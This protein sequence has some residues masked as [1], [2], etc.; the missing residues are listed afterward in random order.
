MVDRK[1]FRL[2]FLIIVILLFETCRKDGTTVES[3]NVTPE[4]ALKAY[5]DNGDTT[6]KWELKNQLKGI[7]VTYFQI[8]LT[9]Q[10]WQTIPWTHDLMVVVP[11][12]MLYNDALLIIN[13]GSNSNGKPNTHS[14]TES[15]IQYAGTVALVQKAV[16]VL[17]WQVPNEPLYG[18]SEDALIS[19]TLS[20]YLG[21]HD[22]NWP[23]LFPMT[24]SAI[25]AM[26]VAQEF[27]KK[28]YN[29]QLAGFVV[30]GA[31]KRGWTTWLTGAV[32]QRVIGIAPMVIDMINMSVN[33][34]YQ[35]KVWGDYS[36]EI[37]DYVKLGITQQLGTPGG[38]ELVKM[39]DPYSYR[40]S[41]NM[42]KIIFMGTNDPYWPVDAVKNY[43]DNIPGNNRLCYTPNAGHDLGNGTT[44]LA[45]LNAFFSIL[46][47]RSI[48]P[49]CDYQ[50]SESNGKVNITVNSSADL[51]DDATLWSAVSVSDQDFRDETWAGKAIVVTDKSVVKTQ[52]DYPS[53][54]YKAFY[55]D[56][57]YKSPLGI[58][59]TVSTRVYVANSSK[60]LL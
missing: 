23:L 41:L 49:K 53:A 12:H 36:I 27:L 6:F 16:V 42:P 29:K 50:L 47:T 20:N 21:D 35:K 7:G 52:I 17:L 5:L 57:K 37:Q 55:I 2:F 59:Y 32:D 38:N 28:Q 45:S 14:F 43:I 11:D 34:D 24:K 22:F 44:A 56:L 31:S 54:G 15:D 8:L 1:Y 3:K 9:S 30:T 19:K 46:L 13:G 26:D 33:I 51:L 60:V 48:L 58:S 18:L 4:T 39:I 40:E 25:K 10:T